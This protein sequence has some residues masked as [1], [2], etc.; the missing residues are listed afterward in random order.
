MDTRLQQAARVSGALAD[1]TRPRIL[2]RAGLVEAVIG[3]LPAIDT[4]GLDRRELPN[5]T[6]CRPAPPATRTRPA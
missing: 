1:A 2:R 3:A 4:I 5:A 6:D